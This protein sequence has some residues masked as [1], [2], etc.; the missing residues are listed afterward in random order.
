MKKTITTTLIVVLSAI[1]VSAQGSYK[2]FPTGNCTNYAAQKFDSVAP[3]PKLN[4]NGNAGVWAQKALAAG[5]RV[6]MNA[7]DVHA[8]SIIV[9]N[10]G[11][12][13][14]VGWIEQVRNG[15]IL[16]S[17]MNWVGFGKVSSTWLPVSNLTR[18]RSGQYR[19]VGY[20]FPS[21]FVGP[22]R[23]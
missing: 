2:G 13:G 19:F 20:I 7:F 14:H 11:G 5:W 4:W 17:E 9:W 23:P 18:G 15:Q 1:A 21:R 16:V 3:A 10:D 6:S 22:I 12:Y 8:Q